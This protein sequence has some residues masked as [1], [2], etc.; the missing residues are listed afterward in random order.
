MTTCPGFWLV[1]IRKATSPDLGWSSDRIGGFRSGGWRSSVWKPFSPST[2]AV[3]PDKP[4]RAEE[5]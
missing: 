1:D 2:A 5:N 3:E 4:V